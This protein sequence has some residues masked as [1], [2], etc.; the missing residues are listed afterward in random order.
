MAK[1]QQPPRV[2]EKLKGR[3]KKPYGGVDVLAHDSQKKGKP[4]ASS[5]A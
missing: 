3:G 2:G 1:D 4:S 5:F